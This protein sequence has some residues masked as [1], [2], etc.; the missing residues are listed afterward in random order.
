MFLQKYDRAKIRTLTVLQRHPDRETW[1]AFTSW[2]LYIQSD[3]FCASEVLDSH[4]SI[5]NSFPRETLYEELDLP[6]IYWIPKMHE[7]SHKH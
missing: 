7:K 1:T 2:E 4:K 3:N 5:L 6:N